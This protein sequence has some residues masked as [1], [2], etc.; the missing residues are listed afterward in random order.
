MDNLLWRREREEVMILIQIS[1]L[2]SLKLALPNTDEVI[3]TYTVA[4][5][6]FWADVIAE[7]CVNN[8]KKLLK[9]SQVNH[10]RW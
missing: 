5:E 6:K 7:A 3:S 2:D 4:S 10:W 9:T 1:S 8:L